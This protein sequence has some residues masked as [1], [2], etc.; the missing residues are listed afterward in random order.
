MMTTRMMLRTVAA[1]VG[2][3]VLALMVNTGCDERRTSKYI[4]RLSDT[5]REQRLAAGYELVSIG[6]PAVAPLVA[7]VSAGSN[8]LRYI[9]AQILGRIGAPSALPIFAS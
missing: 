1:F 4:E 8:S 9:C 2:G 7:A 6:E 5:R 3:L